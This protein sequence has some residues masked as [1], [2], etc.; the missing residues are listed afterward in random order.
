MV[1]KIAQRHVFMTLSMYQSTCVDG[2][3]NIMYLDG[4]GTFLAENGPR[5]ESIIIL[6][7]ACEL[8]PNHGFEKFM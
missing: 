1:N 8:A 3:Q 2:L 6:Q 7:R 4:Y 5:E